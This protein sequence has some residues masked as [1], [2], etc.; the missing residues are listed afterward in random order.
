M[1]AGEVL[2]RR[3]L[4]RLPPDIWKHPEIQRCVF[5]HVEGTE[6]TSGIEAKG[7]YEDS[8]FNEM[9]VA[10]VV[11][12]NYYNKSSKLSCMYTHTHMHT[13]NTQAIFLIYILL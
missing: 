10:K 4:G 11:S 1:A 2:G 13:H 7:S 12:Y 8:K 3:W 5:I 9:E 6:D